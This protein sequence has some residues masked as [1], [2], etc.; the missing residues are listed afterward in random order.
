MQRPLTP[1]LSMI[2]LQV[3]AWPHESVGLVVSPGHRQLST[4]EQPA[5]HNVCE[6]VIE[7]H[8]IAHHTRGFLSFTQSGQTLVC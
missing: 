1:T 8:S 4:L 2:V 3:L 5:V 6:I 7:G